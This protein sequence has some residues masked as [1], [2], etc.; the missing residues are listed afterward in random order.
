MY[1]HE[2]ERKIKKKNVLF[3]IY[4]NPPIEIRN[5]KKRGKSDDFGSLKKNQQMCSIDKRF[6]IFASFM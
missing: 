5:K 3:C 1:T 6:F 2:Y 4:I